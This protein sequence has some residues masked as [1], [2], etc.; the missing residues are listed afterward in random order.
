MPVREIDE[1]YGTSKTH[2]RPKHLLKTELLSAEALTE[3][4]FPSFVAEV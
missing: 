4:A 1:N 3:T 2:D